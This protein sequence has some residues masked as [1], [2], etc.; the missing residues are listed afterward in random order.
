MKK[1]RKFRNIVRQSGKILKGKRDEKLVVENL[2][3]RY[4]IE[5]KM[6]NA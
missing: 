2:D 1:E 6:R 5:K 3:N 4:N